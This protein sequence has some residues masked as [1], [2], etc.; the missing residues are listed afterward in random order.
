VDGIG[1]L[2]STDFILNLRLL[3]IFSAKFCSKLKSQC[4]CR[5]ITCA[6]FC[7]VLIQFELFKIFLQL[8]VAI[9]PQ[10]DSNGAAKR[11]TESYFLDQANHLMEKG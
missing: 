5:Q 2:S 7:N 10:A 4:S 1:F 8:N 11:I 3:V 9:Y 6:S